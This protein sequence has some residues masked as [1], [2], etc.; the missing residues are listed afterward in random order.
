MIELVKDYLLDSSR[1]WWLQL[2]GVFWVFFTGYFALKLKDAPG[3]QNTR[4]LL[5]PER[6]GTKSLE[7]HYRRLLN[8]FLDAVDKRFPAATREESPGWRTAWS[9]SLLDKALLFAVVY[10]I[11]SVMLVWWA[12]GETGFLG[13][14]PVLE[15]ESNGWLRTGVVAIIASPFAVRV[16]TGNFYI[17]LG[18][19][20]LAF[21]VAGAGAVA[22]AVAGAGAGAFAVAVAVAFAVGVAV[23]GAGAGAVA[24]AFAGAVAGATVTLFIFDYLMLRRRTPA[25]AYGLLFFAGCGALILGAALAN[26]ERGGREFLIFYG[27]LP[28]GNALF[29]FLSI[30]ITRYTLRQSA[31]SEGF[32]AR[33]KWSAAD[34]VGAFLCLIGLILILL[35]V[36]RMLNAVATSPIVDLSVIFEAIREDGHSY[37]WLYLTLFSTLLPTV[38]HFGLC[39]YSFAVSRMTSLD[40]VLAGLLDR[41][42]EE[43]D[44]SHLYVLGLALPLIFTISFAAP[45]IATGFLGIWLFESHQDWGLWLLDQFEGFAVFV[46]TLLPPAETIDI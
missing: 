4:R 25:V 26:S 8:A 18:V 12:T 10:P 17:V 40:R 23:A 9:G 30:G 6:V 20:M 22:F 15:A 46:G 31:T 13:T 43:G 37:W 27:A 24:V 19:S 21:A 5:D 44:G 38:F 7:S 39:L 45:I 41:Y 35:F 16:F 3:R 11:F 2:A 1:G 14:V 36:I 32:L 28:L 29:D 34:A 42:N 33:L